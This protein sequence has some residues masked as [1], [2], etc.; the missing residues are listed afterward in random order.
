M[1]QHRWSTERQIQ[2][3]ELTR[4]LLAESPEAAILDTITLVHDCEELASASPDNLNS[5][6]DLRTRIIDLAQ[7]VEAKGKYAG[8]GRLRLLAP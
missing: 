1:L 4:Q 6:G 2:F 5:W 3:Y 8:A 7:L